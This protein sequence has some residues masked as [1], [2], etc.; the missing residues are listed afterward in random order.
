MNIV[1]KI[2]LLTLFSIGCYYPKL[3]A[4]SE[5][6][7]LYQVLNVTQQDTAK[8]NTLLKFCWKLH[9]TD[10]AKTEEFANRSLM[11]S[12]KLAY[13]KG[14]GKSYSYIS[15]VHFSNGDNDLAL[16]YSQ[17]ALIIGEQ[18]NDRDLMAMAY[19][20]IAMIYSEIGRADEALA[21]WQKSINLDTEAGDADNIPATYLNMANLLTKN[22]NHQEA[23]K[24]FLKALEVSK[25]S[26]NT[27]IISA[28]HL[29]IAEMYEEEKN[30]D[31]ASD[32]YEKALKLAKKDEDKE[33]I[34][35]A[36]L[37]LSYINAER[38]NKEMALQ[39][40]EAAVKLTE[41]IGD[42]YSATISNGKLA[43]IQRKLKEYE[44]SLETSHKVIRLS[45]ENNMITI[46]IEAYKDISETYT[47]IQDYKQAYFFSQKYHSLRDSTFSEQKAKNILNLEKKYQSDLK[48]KENTVLKLQQQEQELQ[49]QQNNRFNKT[50]LFVLFLISIVGFLSYRRY[51]DKISAHK[52]LE[53]KVN[54]RT[55]E[56][57]L[58]NKNLETSNKELERFAY[59]ASHDLREPLRNISGF[60]GLLKRELKPEAGSNINEYLSFIT[61]NTS[62]LNTLIQDILTYSKVNK[63]NEVLYD[64]D[65]NTIVKDINKSL[66]HSIKEKKVKIFIKGNL[67]VLKSNGQQVYFL[68]KNLIENGI[69]YNNSEFPR[70]DIICHDIGDKYEFLVKDN[71]IGIDPE[72]SSKVFEMFTR[73]HDRKQFTGTGLGLSLCRKI[74]E[75]HGGTIK[76]NSEKDKGS[77]FVFTWCKEFAGYILENT[78][79]EIQPEHISV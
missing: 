37:G 65:P 10:I 27:M 67:P 32:N 20:D 47:E 46:A 16:E 63:A 43:V 25:T 50:L 6:D 74:V 76:V 5:L 44:K 21:I 49:I 38:G 11:L 53:E 61:N 1:F 9:R 73:L 68:F 72:Y 70:I 13:K 64:V 18:I 62:Q 75:N 23:R 31:K 56:L 45:K 24:Y 66:A 14:K 12:E 28:V 41:T 4:T 57:R 2:I 58:M 60:A 69:K 39:Q 54:E 19:N 36:T 35:F 7:S 33:I 78:I 55:E 51:I 29:G 15:W 26:K 34:A 79:E 17:K 59:I 71:G 77:S 40:A 3:T 30:Y 42:V 48:E 52:L 8:V 22:D